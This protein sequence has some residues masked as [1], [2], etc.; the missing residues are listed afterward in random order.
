MN[1]SDEEYK[2]LQAYQNKTN[3]QVIYPMTDKKFAPAAEHDAND[4]NYWYATRQVDGKTVPVLDENGELTN[5]YKP[6]KKYPDTHSTY[7]GQ[8]ADFYDSIT[9]ESDRDP[10]GRKYLYAQKNQT[11]F[12]V[13]VNYYEYY[14]YYHT[15]IAKDGITEPIF[16]LGTDNYGKDVLTC[17]SAG[18]RLSFI[19]AIVVSAVNMLVG[20]FYGAVES[21]LSYLGIINLNTGDLTSVGTLLANAEPYLH[22]YPYLMFSPALFISLLMLSFNLFG[23]GLRDAFNPSLRGAED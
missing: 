9:I 16:L 8:P 2:N 14:K 7:P 11:G 19:L 1:L 10:A 20:A 13:R 4:A 23:N 12:G 21:S 22:T 6:F 17:L 18:A 3:I 5:I 15:E